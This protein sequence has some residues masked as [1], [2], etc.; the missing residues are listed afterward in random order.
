M[1]MAT[2]PTFSIV[3]PTF[4]RPA[5]LRETLAALLALDYHSDRY[6]IIVVDDDGGG[7]AAEVVRQQDCGGVSVRVESQVRMG[8]ACAR[9]RGAHVAA[10][11]VLLFC[12]DDM[13]LRA[14]GPYGA[15]QNAD[16][17]G[18]VAVSAAW[19][20][21]PVP[22]RTLQASRIRPLSNRAR[23]SLPE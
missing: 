4:R 11:D 22:L 13:L 5:A 19:E 16:R 2:D 15:G 21:A 7:T 12:D 20:F 6:E 9:N 17:H 1:L 14:D 18:D 23:A 3:V 8:A 10:G